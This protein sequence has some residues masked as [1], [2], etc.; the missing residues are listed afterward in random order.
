MKFPISRLT[1]VVDLEPRHETMSWLEFTALLSEPRQSPCT[2]QTC[3]RSSCSHKRGPCWSPAV[4]VTGTARKAETLSL[5]VFDVDRLADDQVDE[6][7]ERLSSLQYMMH[8]THSD[9][10]DSR[11]LRVVIALSRPVSTKVWGTFFH[12]ALR[13]RSL[14][15]DADQRCVDAPRLYF[16]PSCPRDS[17]YFTQVNGGLP[18]DVDAMLAAIPSSQAAP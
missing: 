11:C 9:L 8:S 2:R 12:T 10:P 14:V 18:L 1:S 6:I 15:P 4:F 13:S 7:R 3:L 17:I 16:L 5:L